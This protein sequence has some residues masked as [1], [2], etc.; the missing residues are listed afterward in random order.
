MDAKS[1]A[2]R[3]ARP[4]GCIGLCL[5][6]AGM[7]AFGLLVAAL[8]G[9]ITALVAGLVIGWHGLS[10]M[11]SDVTT[12]SDMAVLLVL[13]IGL[14]FGVAAGVFASAKWFGRGSWRDLIGWRPFRVF[15]G[16]IWAIMTAALIYSVAANAALSHFLARPPAQLTIPS[17]PVAAGLLFILAVLFAPVTEELVFRGWLY[18]GLRFHWGVW[19]AVVTTSALFAAAHYEGTHLYA[20]AVFPIGV[21]LAAIREQTGSVKAAMF[22]HAVNNFAAFGLSMLVRS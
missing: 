20:L 2:S 12:Q 9:A 6:L 13:A 16:R 4:L 22:F 21:A 1:D 3:I 5:S 10:K 17:G 14:Y 15:D 11:M 19:P 18:T 8:I 7:V